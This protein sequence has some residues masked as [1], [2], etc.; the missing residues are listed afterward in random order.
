MNRHI[1]SGSVCR[2]LASALVLGCGARLG[3]FDTDKDRRA[4]QIARVTPTGGK[5]LLG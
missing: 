5:I 1:L 3:L 2:V 4:G